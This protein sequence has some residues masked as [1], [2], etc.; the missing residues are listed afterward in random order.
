[1]NR[2]RIQ[3]FEVSRCWIIESPLCYLARTD[4][5]RKERFFLKSLTSI[6]LTVKLQNTQTEKERER[7]QEREWGEFWVGVDRDRVQQEKRLKRHSRQK[8]YDRFE[9][10][11][12]MKNSDRQWEQFHEHR[13]L[14]SV[15]VYSNTSKRSDELKMPDLSSLHVTTEAS[16]RDMLQMTDRGSKYSGINSDAGRQHAERRT[17]RFRQKNRERLEL[18]DEINISCVLFQRQTCCWN[19][20]LLKASSMYTKINFVP[21]QMSCRTSL[22][23]TPKSKMH[24]L[25]PKTV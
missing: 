4:T 11:G 7:E 21:I 3:Q 13:K 17:V 20:Y 6:T 23:L 18:V 15:K 14:W 22:R 1:M 2:V 5:K 9:I 16:Y 8:A 24:L 19:L 12:F 25:H 10:K